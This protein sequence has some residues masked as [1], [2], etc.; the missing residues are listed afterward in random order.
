MKRDYRL[1][2]LNDEEF[3]D[4][5]TAVCEG[6]LGVGITPFA[7]GRDGGRDAKFHGTAER[8][9]SASDPI[10]GRMV[11]QAKHT[12]GPNKSCSDRDF[13]RLVKKEHPKIK[14][15]VKEGLCDHYLLFTNRKLTGGADEKLIAEIESLGVKTAHI[16]AVEK[17]SAV[18][19]GNQSL[20]D[21][22]P[23]A[24]DKAPFTFDTGDIIEVIGA[25]HDY[26]EDGGDDAFDSARDFDTVSIRT[27]K[28]KINGL[29]ADYYDEIVVGESMI[30]FDRIKRFLRNPRN[31]NYRDL[32]HDAADELKQ[33]ILVYKEEFENFEAV[34]S[35]L[36]DA[37]QK[38]RDALKGK[39]RLVT[40]LLHYMYCNCDIG[41]KHR[42]KEMVNVDA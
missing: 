23:N 13:Q 31:E 22:L 39:R 5:T 27:E 19:A 34:F 29:S 17:L 2:E 20:R 7:E 42:P 35:F 37:V 16:I 30:Y 12:R 38:Q 14:R 41:S 10:A 28:N 18:L 24:R 32:Y 8:F 11:I 36:Y 21:S 3:E 4:L 9:P 26:T 15:L 25:L 6:W 40:I 1:Y 33:K